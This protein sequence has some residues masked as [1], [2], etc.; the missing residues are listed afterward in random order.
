MNAG[1][2]QH[3]AAG[4]AA[5]AIVPGILALLRHDAARYT[6][7]GHWA[8]QSGFW[9]GALYRLG[10]FTRERVRIPI[11]R[12]GMLGVYW[13]IRQPVRLLLHVDIPA[14][15]RIGG[16]LYLPHPRNII[17]GPGVV[18]GED[19]S[20]F[21]DITVGHGP[22]P[23]LATVGNHVVLFPGAK[24]LGGISIGHRSEIGANCVVA[25]DIPEYTLV[26]PAASRIIRQS[27]VRHAPVE[28]ATP[29]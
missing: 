1:A 24:V 14:K 9:V 4:L 8:L 22:R 29:E 3:L 19:C 12:H 27:L 20:I 16:G 13:L 10:A 17:I 21:H 25:R 7:T 6:P 26:L 18:I 5:A 23:G 15:A 11:L 2:H 28:P